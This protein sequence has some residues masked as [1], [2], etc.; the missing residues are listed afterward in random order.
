MILSSVCLGAAFPLNVLIF[1]DVVNILVQPHS[2]SE[3][4]SEKLHHL[5]IRFAMLSSGAFIC[6]F[7]QMITISL[8]ATRQSR[9][10]KS[11]YFNALLRQEIRW[12]DKQQT[13]QLVTK[14]TDDVE[15]IE[16]SVSDKL[17][18]FIQQV[19][20]FGGSLIVA[21]ATG[22]KLSFVGCIAIPMMATTFSL[23]IHFIKKYS[24]A[25]IRAYSIAG[26]IAEEILSSI[27]TVVAFSAQ[28]KE[29]KRYTANLKEA[30]ILGSKKSLC[31][32]IGKRN[33]G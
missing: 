8:T 22:W 28:D 32:G 9:R 11:H 29:V 14:L 17:A 3:S 20:S 27:R 19:A 26:G 25:Q 1:K 13:G 12:Y 15:T 2:T 7:I 33:D 6:G 23:M 31:Q 24:I 18:V 30:E 16:V 10:L 21:L 4:Y 5:I